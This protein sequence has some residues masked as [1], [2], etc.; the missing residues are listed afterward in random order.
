MKIESS[1]QIRLGRTDEGGDFCTEISISW[2]PVGAKKKEMKLSG[3]G[4]ENTAGNNNMFHDI[5]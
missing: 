1:W 3:S 4:A 5:C 2:A